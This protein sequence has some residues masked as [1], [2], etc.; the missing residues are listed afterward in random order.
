MFHRESSESKEIKIKRQ[1]GIHLK[2]LY[3]E[4]YS[5]IPPLLLPKDINKREFAFQPFEFNSYVRHISFENKEAFYKYMIE[6]TPRQA[7]Y[8]IARYDLPEANRM[9]EKGWRGSDLLFDIDL[10][11]LPGCE[12]NKEIIDDNCIMKGLEHANR[13]AH[14]IKN[15]LG[16]TYQIYFT[17]N[18]GYHVRGMCE[19]CIYLGREERAEIANFIAAKDL[20]IRLIFPIAKKGR[21]IAKPTPSDPGWRGLIAKAGIG[22]EVKEESIMDAVS[23]MKVDIDAMVTQDPTRLT[24][25]PGTINGKASLLVVPVCRDFKIGRWLSPFSG[26]LEVTSKKDIDNIKILGI[27]LSMRRGEGLSLPSQLAIYLATKGYVEVLEG[28]VVVRKNTGWWPIQGCDWT[29]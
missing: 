21:K 19:Q 1:R 23:K 13:I 29:T 15:Y 25:I 18:R 14:I 28:E 8:S 7:Y 12:L 24:R 26:S 6:N 3:S 20:D 10:D 2:A 5:L 22:D 17:G 16:G 4:Y 11:H 27:N 9:E